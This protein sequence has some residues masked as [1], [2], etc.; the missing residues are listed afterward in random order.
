MNRELK[1][2]VRRQ[3]PF[4]L[5][6][7]CTVAEACQLMHANRVGAVLVTGAGGA[8]AGIFTGR[9][10]VRALAERGEA[11]GHRLREVMTGNPTC[12]HPGATAIDALRLMSDC[13]FRHIPI[14]DQG[15]IV[16]IVSKGDFRGLEHDRLDAETGFWERM[17]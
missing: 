12:L 13:G 4:T 14:V 15:R 17:R 7:Q 1:E 11:A 9:D 2:V 10:A 3:R 6:A 16:G 8:L 5:D